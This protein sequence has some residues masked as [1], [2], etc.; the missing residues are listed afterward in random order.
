[1]GGDGI[2]I[3]STT[4]TTT[5]A[6]WFYGLATQHNDGDGIEIGNAQGNQFSNFS[7]ESNGGYG[8][9]ISDASGYYN[10]FRGWIENNTSGSITDAAGR[11]TFFVFVGQSPAAATLK[12]ANNIVSVNT[13]LYLNK[14]VYLTGNATF[15]RSAAGST[16]FQARVDGDTQ[17]R[18]LFTA[19]GSI[20][21]GPGSTTVVDTELKRI[22]VNT[23]GLGT[24]DIL[25]LH[26]ASNEFR[27]KHKT[28]DSAGA[29]GSQGE[30]CWDADYIYVCVDTDTWERVAIATW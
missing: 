5:N 12:K 13:D 1:M 27:L 25:D 4:S 26:A 24:N 7:S 28:P 21:F 19:G 30:I 2:K 20:L 3:A 17:P 11:N 22:A 15:E 23:I 8:I 10:Q 6:N 29:T 14:L 18:S 16:A 9:N